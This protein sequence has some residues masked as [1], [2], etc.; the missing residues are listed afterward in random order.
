MVR[1]GIRIRRPTETIQMPKIR[2]QSSNIRSML[3]SR[4]LR[5]TSG[6]VPGMTTTNSDGPTSSLENIPRIPIPT[7]TI[8][9][10]PDVAHAPIM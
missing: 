5:L 3:G 2:D 8:P 7:R 6:P 1:G 4:S 10:R 9:G